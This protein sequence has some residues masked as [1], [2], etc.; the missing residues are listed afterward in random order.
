MCAMLL[1]Q[2]RTFLGAVLY[3]HFPELLDPFIRGNLGE[4]TGR[5][6]ERVTKPRA[7]TP[8]NV[9]EVGA[10]AG[11]GAPL[12]TAQVKGEAQQTRALEHAQ[13]LGPI[14]AIAIR[15][16]QCFLPYLV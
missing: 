11:C 8:D 5:H 6:W 2:G 13:A 16:K 4:N 15:L 7:L 3:K 12:C 1:T 14:F 9:E 10:V